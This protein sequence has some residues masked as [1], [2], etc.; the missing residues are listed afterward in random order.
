MAGFGQRLFIAGYLTLLLS[1]ADVEPWN[2]LAGVLSVFLGVIL[3]DLSTRPKESDP[4]D[5]PASSS[6]S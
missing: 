4:C 3:I 1:V 2:M 6:P 5:L